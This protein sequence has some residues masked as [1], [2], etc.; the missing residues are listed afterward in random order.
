MHVQ[1]T[2]DHMYTYTHAYAHNMVPNNLMETRDSRAM[3]HLKACQNFTPWKALATVLVARYGSL[4]V[5]GR[6]IAHA[7]CS[8]K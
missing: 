4:P 1:Y 3:Y 2:Y 8:K 7:H 6:V 5:Y